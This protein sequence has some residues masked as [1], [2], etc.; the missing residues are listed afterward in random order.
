MRSR[1]GIDLG[2][3]TVKLVVLGPGTRLLYKDYR[4][5]NAQVA[6]TLGDMIDAAKKKIGDV[7]VSVA[8]TGSAGLGVA[9]R[10][11]IPF[12][13][14]VIAAAETVRKQYGDVRTLIDVGG[15][16]S[17][18]IFF[19]D[20]MRVD[21]RMNGNCAGGTG[22]FI[23]QMATLLHVPLKELDDLV[24]R[25]STVHPIAS[26]CGVFAKTDVQNLISRRIGKEDIATSVF[27]AVA[28]QTVSTLSRGYDPRSKVL[29]CGGPFTFLPELKKSYMDVLDLSDADMVDPEHPEMVPAIG[30]ALYNETPRLEVTLSGLKDILTGEAVTNVFLGNHLDPLFRND[31]EYA[32]W[33]SRR[34]TPIGRTSSLKEMDGRDCFLGI[35]TGSTT[36]KVVLIDADGKI[37]YRYYGNNQGD[38]I[39]AVRDG[40]EG[41]RKN[42]EGLDL[43]IA[44]TAVTGYGEDLIKAAFGLDIGMVETLAHFRAAREFL[45]EVS[46]IL[47]IGGQDMKAI[48][49]HGGVINDIEINEACSSGCGSFIET[50]ANN[51]GESVEEFALKACHAKQ[52]YDLGTRCTVFM[53]SKVK[54]ALREGAS[55]GD[56]SAGLAFS[57]VKNCLYK[58]LKIKDTDVLGDRIVV[59]GGTFRNPAVHRALE[60]ILGT[61]VVC[62][63]S[64][65]LMGAYGAAL[66]A[67]DSRDA[68]MG[69]STF[70]GLDSLSI[71]TDMTAQQIRCQ[72]CQNNCVVTRMMFR[73]GKVFHTGNKCE[74]IFT[75]K[76]RDA[77]KGENLAD[78]KLGLLFDRDLVPKNTPKG[79]IGIPRVLNMFENFPFWSTLLTGC[80]FEVVLSPPS[81]SEIQELGS[82]SVMSENICFPAKLV[83][84]HVKKLTSIGVDRI[85]LPVVVYEKEE[86]KGALN[87]FN[88][89]VVSGYPDVVRS[90]VDPAGSYGIPFD[91]P[92][93]SFRSET[94]L[95][96]ASWK[97]LK[98]LGVK[99]RSFDRAF[100][101][102]CRVQSGYKEQV[103]ER[104]L[105]ILAKAKKDRRLV[106]LLVGRPYHID[107]LIDH[108]ITEMICNMGADVITEDSVPIEDREIKGIG[109]LTQWQYPNRVYKAVQWAAGQDNVEVVQLNSFGCG[110]DALVCDEARTILSEAGKN[111]TLIRIDEV[112]SPGSINL[113]LRSMMESIE[114]RGVGKRFQPIKRKTTPPY[115][116]QDRKKKIIAPDMSRFY[117]PMIV[118]ALKQQGYEVDILPP[119]DRESVEVGLKYCNNEICYPA[120]IVIG[121]ILKALLSGKY[122]P[123]EVVA[124]ITQTGGQCRASSY[125]SLLNKALTTAGFDNVPIMTLTTSSLPLNYQPGMKINMVKLLRMGV[126]GVLFADSIMQMYYA[127]AVRE[128]SKGEADRVT[129]KYIG[130]ASKAIDH[131]REM[132]LVDLLERAVFE[133]N[134]IE[135]NGGHLPTI[136]IVGE[137]FVKYNPFANYRVVDWMVEHGIEVVV[138]PIFDFFAQEYLNQRFHIDSNTKNRDMKYWISYP[139]E[140]YAR[141]HLRRYEKTRMK[142]KHYRKN[143]YIGHLS[144]NA[145]DVVSM[146]NQFGE[147]WLIPA[148]IGA[149]AE[150]NVNHVVCLQPFGCISNHIIGKGVEK[151]LKAKYPDLNVLYLDMDAGSSEVNLYNRLSFIVRSAREDLVRSG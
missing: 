110:P 66:T 65:E 50:F 115:S 13:Q 48:F 24:K 68:S 139:E 3:T 53:N 14:E 6:G 44:G 2:S 46:F 35:D 149:F 71:A 87:T 15:E 119:A 135:T 140:W 126:Q 123:E 132:E 69:A 5:H 32:Q 151:A 141:Y 142:F 134:R 84:G 120:I 86:F 54:Q 27:H 147:G 12:V 148:E 7:E 79:R 122:D 30:T 136:G 128:V 20:R 116:E 74:R 108:K 81:T 9:E 10:Y 88:C 98:D 138:P 17:K 104:A 16:D 114:K 143:H 23:D 94:L 47:D 100:E 45:P 41:L 56:I 103:K 37:V 42:S 28:I 78:I 76:G 107:H 95:R 38:P 91:P 72:G 150:E 33:A 57:V 146:V 129:D 62:S 8:I 133:F 106:V 49:I 124:G 52:P 58:V 67:M 137:I 43:R 70:I 144:K 34:M 22:A 105:T 73:S 1:L 130:L 36:T 26:R 125:L 117:S 11:N 93:V 82:R 4:R 113:R 99:R 85:F 111:H 97:Y 101:Q 18:M 96:K 39:K 59:Q 109:V 118:S 131:G 90:A 25:S 75:N 112:S 145:K 60:L 89:P 83:N 121:D 92:T 80:G 29:L 55:V 21:I 31:K 102:A 51:L 19:D 61:E 127:T 63:D 77:P 40:L 64:P